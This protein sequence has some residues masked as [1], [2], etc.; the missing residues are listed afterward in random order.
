MYAKK[1]CPRASLEAGRLYKHLLKNNF[2]PVSNPRKADLIF[3]F[4]CGGFIEFEERSILTIQKALKNKSA[5]IIVTGCLPKVNPKRIGEFKNVYV[6]PKEDLG[7][8]DKILQTDSSYSESPKCTIAD[9]IHD[10][11]NV[12]FMQEAKRRFAFNTE[13]SGFCSSYWK[14]YLYQRIPRRENDTSFS[15]F[16]NHTYKL[17]IAKGCL[18]SCSYCAIKLAMPKFTS[19]PEK[20]IVESLKVGLEAGYRHFA[21]LAGDIGCYGLDI[22]TNL[23]S[24]LDELFSVEGNYKILLVD[25]NARWFVKYYSELVSVI[26][27]NFTKVARVIIPIQS[28]SNRILELMNRN[29]EIDDVKKCILD[30]QMNIPQ[31]VLDT[32]MMVGFPGET[33]EDF[34]KSLSLIR[35]LKF[36][37]VEI[38]PYDDRPS[39]IASQL[40]DKNS[41]EVIARRVKILAKEAKR[42]KRAYVFRNLV[43]NG[44]Y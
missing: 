32:H 39:T 37:Y 43:K 16:S 25:L 40:P 18:G 33:D 41:K 11:C 44:F 15:V 31:V 26:K 30:F 24:L 20:Q 36:S 42:Q 12:G 27:S 2:E 23:P 6:I 22:K 19:Y 17:E 14:N 9:G 29:Y 34:G 7:E 21:V 28:G 35:D 5:K 4:T 1:F 8:L 13:F 10:L 38:Y 3:V